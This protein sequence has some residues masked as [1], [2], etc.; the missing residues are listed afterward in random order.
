[1]PHSSPPSAGS[2]PTRSPDARH[3][4]G[5]PAYAHRLK[6]DVSG[7]AENYGGNIDLNEDY[8]SRWT[9]AKFEELESVFRETTLHLTAS[10][11]VLQLALMTRR[12]NVIPECHVC[13]QRHR[14]MNSCGCTSHAASE[15]HQPRP[16]FLCRVER[17]CVR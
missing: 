7:L 10:Y 17:H 12:G 8:W 4:R 6:E 9:N 13:I 14:G 15:L 1:M 2:A 16:P 3:L 5:N 11:R